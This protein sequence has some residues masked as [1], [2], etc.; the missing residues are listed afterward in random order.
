MSTIFN[1]FLWV[2]SSEYH[3]KSWLVID[4]VKAAMYICPVNLQTL[5]ILYSLGDSHKQILNV[6]PLSF[7]VGHSKHPL[8]IVHFTNKRKSIRQQ[9]KQKNYSNLRL[10]TYFFHTVFVLLL[11]NS[12]IVGS[13]YNAD[14]LGN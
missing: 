12:T 5:R 13:L 4:W 8:K 2:Y 1:N 7:R 10:F 6:G 14:H 3:D 9:Q 11:M